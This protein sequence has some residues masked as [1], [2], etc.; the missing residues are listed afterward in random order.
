MGR[1]AQDMAQL[2]STTLHTAAP[3]PV[4]LVSGDFMTRCKAGTRTMETMQ[5]LTGLSQY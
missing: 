1:Q 3:W 4:Q 2:I 5:V